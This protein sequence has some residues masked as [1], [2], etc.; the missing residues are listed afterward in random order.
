MSNST[1]P[2]DRRGLR[3][4]YPVE[5]GG[6]VESR[7]IP[8]V[9]GVLGDFGRWGDA[10]RPPL[11][12]RRFTPLS[13]DDIDRAAARGH[14]NV[15]A[16]TTLAELAVA[17]P[18]IRV[19]ALDVT[20]EELAAD[21]QARSDQSVLWSRVYEEQYGVFGGA[22]FAMMVAGFPVTRSAADLALL[23]GMARVGADAAC[24]FIVTAAPQMFGIEQWDALPPPE[25]LDWLYASRAFQEWRA[26]REREYARFVAV[27][28]QGDAHN[29]ALS[30][31]R[32]FMERELWSDSRRLAGSDSSGQRDQEEGAAL[33]RYGFLPGGTPLREAS[34]VQRPTRYFQPD[35]SAESECARRL[36]N[37]LTASRFLQAATCIGRDEIGGYSTLKEFGTKLN[38]WLHDYIDDR[39][40]FRGDGHAARPLADGS[41]T[42][43]DV[44]GAPGKTEVVVDLRLT[45]DGVSRMPS[46]RH[47]ML[48]VL[49]LYLL[50][51]VR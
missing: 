35:R 43:R 30:L 2:S 7:E 36:T 19:L 1:A 33:A 6:G 5:T 25:R 9:V 38:A 46:T 27:T 4:A 41:F 21:L 51:P 49:P 11:R 45:T 44:L 50:H 29:V 26:L 22:P 20:K 14:G 40:G 48:T 23:D 34:T 31:L 8:L 42:V 24:P 16:L 32:A 37:V 13:A 39:S 15:P 47:A 18:T 28:V 17:D 3:L 10:D 12:E